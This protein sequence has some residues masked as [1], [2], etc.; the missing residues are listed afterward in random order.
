MN[1]KV[2]TKLE[3]KAKAVEILEAV[4]LCREINN[5]PLLKIMEQLKEDNMKRSKMI[6]KIICEL[7]LNVPH[8]K[9]EKRSHWQVSKK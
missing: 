7:Y 6:R 2:K 9:N 5:F 8:I 4:K 1:Y 3:T